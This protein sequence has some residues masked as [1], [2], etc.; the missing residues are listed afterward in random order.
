MADVTFW[1][2]ERRCSPPQWAAER[3][4]TGPGAFYGD[5]HRAHR[6]PTQGHAEEAMRRMA[7]TATERGDYFV[8]EHA[9]VIR[10]NAS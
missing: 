3:D 4:P 1:A 8:S 5:I 10:S 9:M 2:I 6:F 7:I